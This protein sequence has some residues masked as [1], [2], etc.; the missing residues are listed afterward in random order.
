MIFSRGI[1]NQK[2][3]EINEVKGIAG[4][5][6]KSSNSNI[7]FMSRPKI[8]ADVI[9]VIVWLTDSIGRYYGRFYKNEKENLKL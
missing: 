6:E 4:S 1:S 8:Y 3:Y 5:F 9:D 2:V 7:N